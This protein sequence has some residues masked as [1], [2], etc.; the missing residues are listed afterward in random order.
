VIEQ[1]GVRIR[2]AVAGDAGEIARIHVEAWRDAYA[3]LLPAAYLA[4]L[5]PKIEAARWMR[6]SGFSRSDQGTLV[7]EAEDAVVGYAITGPARWRGAT[8]AG[9]IYALYV[10]TDW[11]EQG[12]GR[13][14]VDF[15]FADFRRRSYTLAMIWCLEGNA[16]ARGFYE[17]CGGRL[18]GQ[19]RAEEIRGVAMPVVGFEWQL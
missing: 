18:L 11:R 4:R 15:A 13:A 10:E 2:G 7:A 5:D 16:A 9:E 14:L 3:T 8:A 19:R 1:Q 17:R 6:S 12:I